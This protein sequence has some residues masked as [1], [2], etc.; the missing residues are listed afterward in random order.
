MQNLNPMQGHRRQV[1]SAFLMLL[2]VVSALCSCTHT[3]VAR[4]EYYSESAGWQETEKAL[5]RVHV[6]C[7][8]ASGHAFTDR[9][10]KRV[11]LWIRKQGLLVFFGRYEVVTA[12]F[13]WDVTWGDSGSRPTVHFYDGSDGREVL[14][15]TFEYDQEA[16]KFVEIAE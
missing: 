5:Y 13:E 2:L 12:G 4:S 9:T 6:E 8:G 15:V 10:K 1:P 11:Y 3:W 14:A 7:H 16:D